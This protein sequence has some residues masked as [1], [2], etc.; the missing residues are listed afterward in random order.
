MQIHPSQRPP[1][2]K[3]LKELSL[4]LTSAFYELGQKLC[5]YSE[6]SLA[7]LI[8]YFHPFSTTFMSSC[9]SIILNILCLEFGEV[10]FSFFTQSY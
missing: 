8:L 2:G 9:E 7:K 10:S 5:Q 6:Q 4:N 3:I 1:I